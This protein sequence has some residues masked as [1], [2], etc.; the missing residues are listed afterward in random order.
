MY[1]IIVHG[2]SNDNLIVIDSSLMVVSSSSPTEDLVCAYPVVLH[3]DSSPGHSVR[4]HDMR[5]MSTA[6]SD[7]FQHSHHI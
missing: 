7:T 3:P 5:N 6:V 4:N 2:E 1:N